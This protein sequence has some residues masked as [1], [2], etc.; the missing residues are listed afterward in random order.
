MVA[1]VMP[2]MNPGSDAWPTEQPA[3]TAPTRAMRAGAQVRTVLKWVN[4]PAGGVALLVL[5][6]LLARLAFAG[7]LG[8]GIDESYMVAS[9]RTLR[10]G[11]FD[12]P[13][14]A[15]WMAWTGRGLLGQPG[16]VVAATRWHDA[17]KIDYALR[18]QATVLCLGADPRQYGL[19]ASA[20]DHAGEDVLVVAPRTSLAQVIT[21][22]GT[23][24]DAPEALPPAMVQHA[25]RPAMLP[26]LFMGHRPHRPEQG[27]YRLPGRPILDQDLANPSLGHFR[28]L[29]AGRAGSAAFSP[30]PPSGVTRTQTLRRLA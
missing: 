30:V 29:G 12:H 9:G 24:F 5:T 4:T 23:S 25:G 28:R 17:G 10:L 3:S 19:I 27:R 16:L 18:G 2:A 6:T 26:P 13:P 15:W 22:F 1:A 14:L 20:G 21:Q 7:T 8:L 11:C